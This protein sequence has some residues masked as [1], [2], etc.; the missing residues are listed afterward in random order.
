MKKTTSAGLVLLTLG[1]PT[2]AQ[3]Q[4]TFEL[5]EIVVLPLAVPTEEDRTGATVET[6]DADDL[7]TG[8]SF[9]LGEQLGLLPGVNLARQ[10]PPGGNGDIQI[11]G[12]RTR[13]VAVYFDGILV[14]DPSAPTTQ[15]DYFGGLTTGNLARV[16]ILKGAQSALYGG[17]AVA[18]VVDIRSNVGDDLGPGTHQAV[19]IE[20]GSYGT[21]GG[22]YAFT[23]NTD[24][25]SLDF[26]IA[27]LVTSGFSAAD[28][29]DGNTEP[30]GFDQTRVTAGARYRISPELSVGVNGFYETGR[31]DYDE[32][33]PVIADGTPNEVSFRDT[34]GA[35]VFAEYDGAGL[36]NDFTLT[37]YETDRRTESD[38][39]PSRFRGNRLQ[40]TNVTTFTLSDRTRASLGLDYRRETARYT[41]LTTG[42]EAVN[43]Y[44]AF[45]EVAYAPNGDLDIIATARLDEHSAFG[46][47]DTA[48][49]AFARRF[50]GGTTLRG[51]LATGYRAPSIDE[52]YG[53]YSAFGFTG[54]PDLEPETSITAE[55]GVDHAYENGAEVSATLFWGEIDNLITITPDFSTL[56]NVAGA[57][58]RQGIE[59]SGRM[60]LSGGASLYGAATF[61]EARGADGT[62]IP[63]TPTTDIVIGAEVPLTGRL[64]AMG[65]ARFVSGL[66]DAGGYLPSF[67]VV[68][69]AA[70]Y[71]LSERASAYLRIENVLNAEYQTTRGY[72]TSDR[73]FYAGLRARF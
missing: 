43:I 73:A 50:G 5:G 10:G 36:D 11:R 37:W 39:G 24:T 33:F 30:D 68:N 48:R 1:L 71:A 65:N 58:L 18:G 57:S 34:W 52:L 60:P 2:L 20:G 62:P 28:E 46:T 67:T 29:N 26:G 49:L 45:A 41:N 9:V 12:A 64:T 6:L 15:F 61:L 32:S 25:L 17:T 72:G 55:I 59:L 14:T 44:G 23:R 70:E 42:S 21:I 63:R 4:S 7:E 54:N 66:Y 27:S 69:A 47:F 19:A 8:G 38:F 53:D 31:W 13:Y 16:E 35:R 3:A 56:E 51:A 22:S 40:A